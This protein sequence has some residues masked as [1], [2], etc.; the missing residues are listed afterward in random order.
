MNTMNLDAF[1]GCARLL[2]NHVDPRFSA[3]LTFGHPAVVARAPG[4]L[5]VMGGIADYSGSLVLQMPIAEGTWVL[6]QSTTDG[7]VRVGSVGLLDGT[8]SRYFEVPLDVL[9]SGEFSSYEGAEH[10]FKTHPEDSWAAYVLGVLVVLK[11]RGGIVLEHGLRL[12]VA[13]EVP[14]GKGVSSSAALEV[15][16][17]NAVLGLLGVELDAKQKALYAHEAENRVAGAPCGVMDPMA[18][19]CGRHGELLRLLC[20]PATIEGYVRIPNELAV[21]GIDSG[22]RH[23]ITGS[24]YSSVR[25]GA[26]MGYRVLLGDHLVDNSDKYNGY[27]ANVTVSRWL[28]G[29]EERIPERMSGA[30]FLARYGR[31]L[32]SVTHID[33]TRDYAVRKPTAHP[34]YE[35][36][37]CRLF[38]A[39][40]DN[41]W[42]E[43]G[44][45]LLGELMYQSHTSYSACGLGSEATDRLVQLVRELGPERGLYGARITGGGSGG[46]IAILAKKDAESAITEVAAR[47]EQKTN[48]APKVFRGT[49]FGVA[50]FGKVSL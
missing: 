39:L 43:E 31:H 29:L 25:V 48:R 32:D 34:I 10:Y 13:S 16:T 28:S 6:A 37:R 8:P 27:L 18:C 7:L 40:L 45:R 20:Q 44:A 41:E 24:D 30:E 42:S 22:V 36:H 19:Q 17:L 50:S 35:H 2:R 49:S 33:P 9:R 46:T 15:A 11:V 26:F 21:Y 14:E 4:R 12:F 1:L 3:L 5:D 47:Y 38:A 23:A